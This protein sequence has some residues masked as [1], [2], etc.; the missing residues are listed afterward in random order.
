MTFLGILSLLQITLLPGL[1]FT[2]TFPVGKP[3]TKII[4]SFSLSL[5]INYQLVFLLTIFSLYTRTSVLIIFISE[6]IYL[7]FVY[8]KKNLK[9][10]L[11][12]LSLFGPD[13]E[14]GLLALHDSYT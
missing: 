4:L 6:I 7:F 12:D 13:T 2:Q 5:I 3:L 11:K 14:N 1:I 9:A 10:P 8:T